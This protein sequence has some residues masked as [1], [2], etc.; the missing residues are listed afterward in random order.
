MNNCQYT[1][2]FTGNERVKHTAQGEERQFTN[3]HYAVCEC[4]I[5]QSGEKVAVQ[6]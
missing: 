5:I 4:L 3:P 6:F 2:D 1:S